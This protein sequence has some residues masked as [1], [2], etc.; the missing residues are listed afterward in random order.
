MTVGEIRR[1][2]F[3]IRVFLSY[4]LDELIP[5][6]R[7]TL[8]LRFWRR[9]VF[10]IPNRHSDELLGVRLRLALE[11]LGPVW[12]KLGQMLSTRRDLFPPE[13]ADQLAALQDKVPPFD[14]ALAK[15]QIEKSLGGPVE[16]WFDDFDIKPLASAS[17]AQVHTA[18]LKENGQDVVIKVIRPD[19]LPVIKADMRLIY[20]LAHWLPRLLPMADVCVR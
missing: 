2:Y 19:I 13:I 18:K 11:Q 17:I 9:C 12:I 8:L 1:L 10:W 4:G 15:A 5:K 14:G 7:L 20:R 16:Q 6:T 3:I